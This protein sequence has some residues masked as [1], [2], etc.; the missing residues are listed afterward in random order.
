VAFSTPESLLLR[1]ESERHEGDRIRRRR[2]WRRGNNG[3]T[4]RKLR[5]RV[6]TWKRHSGVVEPVRG[7]R[8]IGAQIS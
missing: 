2:R 5:G 8:N 3:L 1:Q 7:S 6:M 4:N